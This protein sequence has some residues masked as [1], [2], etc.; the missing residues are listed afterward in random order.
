MGDLSLDTVPTCFASGCIG[1]ANDTVDNHWKR[2]AGVPS[3]DWSI[4][5]GSVRVEFRKADGTYQN[6]TQEWLDLGFSRG[7]QTPD[8]EHGRANTENANAIMILQQRRETSTRGTLLT[9]AF[10]NTGGSH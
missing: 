8:S 2:P 10:T 6:V 9:T 5:G 7:L 1:A 4:L 3:G